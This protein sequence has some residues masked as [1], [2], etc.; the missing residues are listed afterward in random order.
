VFYVNE[1][2]EE[3]VFE[4]LKYHSE[5]GHLLAP[6]CIVGFPPLQTAQNSFCFP[7]GI[8]GF[9]PAVKQI[10]NVASLP[11]I[12]GVS[13]IPLVEIAQVGRG[14]SCI[15]LLFFQSKGICWLARHA[16]RLRFRDRQCGC[17]YAI[18]I[19]FSLYLRT[20]LISWCLLS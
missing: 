18:P 15:L 17:M 2:L 16:F 8:G 3:L 20:I 7:G 10:G 9:L 13:V 5:R 11:G 6:F 19:I 4:E 12:V 14:S 1:H